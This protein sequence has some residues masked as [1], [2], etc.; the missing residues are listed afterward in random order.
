[1]EF[2]FI[3]ALFFCNLLMVGV[4]L[5][6]QFVTYPSFKLIHKKEFSKFHKA[7]T[8]K[9]LF[10]VGPIMKIEFLST[11]ILLYRNTNFHFCIQFG[12]VSLI[13]ILTFFLI[14][15][16]HKKLENQFDNKLNN[17]LTKLNGFRTS[18]WIL[19]LFFLVVI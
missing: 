11:F 19:K 1:M 16:I 5:I 14:V 4:S 9:M 2:L 15:P 18:I 7:Y 10:I 8:K 12:L 3:A 13:W 17:K 6:T